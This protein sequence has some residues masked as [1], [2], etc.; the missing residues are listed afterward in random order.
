MLVHVIKSGDWLKGYLLPLHER[1][2]HSHK[3]L[4][5]S[6]GPGAFGEEKSRLPVAHVHRAFDPADERFIGVASHADRGTG[7]VPSTA[8]RA[9]E[10]L[11]K[12]ALAGRNDAV[13]TLDGLY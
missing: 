4:S 10:P 8:G 11:L 2:A 3:K 7:I 12:I 9:A 1:I 5:P 13:P 6:A